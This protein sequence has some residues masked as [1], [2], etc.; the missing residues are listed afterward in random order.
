MEP[1]ITRTKTYDNAEDESLLR[2]LLE[3]YRFN[4]CESPWD[5]TSA[6]AVRRRVYVDAGGYTV[7]VPDEYDRRSWLLLARE[8]RSGEAVGSVRITPRAEGALE[9]E[10]Y[11]AL[12]SRLQSGRPVEISRLAILP[13]HRKSRTFL[14]IVSLGLFKLV[15]RFLEM[16]DADYMVIC[17]RPE[18]IW[19]FDWMRFNRTGM[20][21]PYAKLGN[22]EHE[23][24]WYDFKHKATILEGHPFRKFFLELDYREVRLPERPPHLGVARGARRDRPFRVS[25]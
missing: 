2:R 4:V 1:H 18:R 20:V 23:L 21:A 12:P 9:A 11:F 7:S 14:P 19:T 3:G 5:I 8:A 13:S 17:S 15:M 6:L 16:I 22:A 25:A 24:L 10:E